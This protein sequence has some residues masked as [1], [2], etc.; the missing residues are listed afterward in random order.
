MARSK[1]TRIQ[2]FYS[3]ATYFTFPFP[4]LLR[5]R[6]FHLMNVRYANYK[7]I[8]TTSMLVNQRV[9]NIAFY[10]FSGLLGELILMRLK[11]TLWRGLKR[12]DMSNAT[13]EG[14]LKQR[15]IRRPK[16]PSEVLLNS[17]Y[18]I[19]ELPM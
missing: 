4:C 10:H 13:S 18:Q 16:G 3:Y 7:F 6:W 17:K 8:Q 1:S 15:Q 9:I 12:L 2:K 5:I 14:N 11:L 19:D